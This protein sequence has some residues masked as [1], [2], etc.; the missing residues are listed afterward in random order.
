LQTLPNWQNGLTADVADD[1][2]LFTGSAWAVYYY[3]GTNWK[4]SGSGLNQNT[5]PIPAG[6]G[7]F[8][9]R[10]STASGTAST[11]TQTLPYTLN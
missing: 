11:L 10:Q 5:T 6:T 3:N 9:V 8:V 1:V 7:I 4:K 2:Y